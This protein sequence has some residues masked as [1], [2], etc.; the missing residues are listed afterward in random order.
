RSFP[1]FL[2]L[3]RFTAQYAWHIGVHQLLV[4]VHPR[5]ARF[6]KRF[7]DFEPIG[8]QRS[9]PSVRNHPAIAMM[10]DMQRLHR[11]RS[12]S[13]HTLFAPAIDQEHLKPQPITDLQ[14]DYFSLIVD[15][16]FKFAPL[17]NDNARERSSSDDALA[18]TV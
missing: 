7:M 9:Y 16:N 18:T 4:A 17:G 10:L 5:H 3:C 1:V 8:E 15:S 12:E 2:R 6:Y 11:E 14:R 13:Y